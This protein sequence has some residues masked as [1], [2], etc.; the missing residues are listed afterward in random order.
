MPKVDDELTRRLHRAERPVERDGLF[1]GLERRR[2]RRERLR[3][4]QAGMLAFAVLA[5]TAGGF[6]ILREAFDTDDRD[7]GESPSPGVPS[8]NGEIVFSREAD[9][10]RLHLFASK[11]DGTGLRQI[12]SEP[13]DDSDP[14]V[15]PDGRTIAYVRASDEVG[16]AIAIVPLEGG[17]VTEL[18]DGTFVDD[19]AWSPDGAEVAFVTS[20]ID[21]MWVQMVGTNGQLTRSFL[22]VGTPISSPSWSPDGTRIAFGVVPAGTSPGS[23]GIIPTN[24]MSER[25][26]DETIGVGSAPAWSPDGSKIA[27]IR[28]GDE[29]DE[30]WTI[31][32]DGTAE[33]LI[34]TWVEGSL[35]PDL[36]WAPDGTALLVSDGTWIYQVEAVP[37]GDPRDNFVRLMEGQSPSWQPIPADSDPSP[38]SSPEPSVSPEPEPAGHNIGLSFRLCHLHP[39]GG[40]D[41]LGDGPVN[42][43]WTG[44]RVTADG[45]CSDEPNAS[46][47]VAVDL[48]GD[49]LADAWSGDTIQFCFMCRP[50]AGVDFDADGD[51][52]LAVMTSEGSMPTF[53]IYAATVD[54]GEPRVTPILAAAPGHPSGGHEA[55]QPLTYTTGGD[56][57]FSGSVRCEGFP[58]APVL[59]TTWSEHPIEGDT[60]T[61]HETKLVLGADSAFYVVD[62]SDYEAPVAATIPGT[63]E[64]TACGVDWE[65]WD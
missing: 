1:E 27:L 11:P 23:V 40:L 8:V 20:G 34:A 50:F 21:S 44:S 12:T 58:D 37:V 18:A 16:L 4:V 26:L 56:A 31:A 55:G 32:P 15:S 30:I 65:L 48:T 57:G 43:A 10:G 41:L 25:P 49:G 60:K 19:P 46:F 17:D 61:V 36:A 63:S 53:A 35:Q 2:S 24:T 29:G 14:A 51:D 59:V 38:T 62:S 64:P 39:L 28:S 5:A 45:Q 47:G 42:K 6:A 7:V 9:D 33:T 3:R 22:D 13:T 54:G 52:E